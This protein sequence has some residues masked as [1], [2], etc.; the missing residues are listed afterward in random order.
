M[1]PFLLVNTNVVRPPVSPVGL[2]YVAETLR[3]AGLPV[4]V[5]D[6]A[7]EA[8]WRAALRKQLQSE[9]LGVGLSVRNTDD[10]SF[11]T[12]QSFLPW[13]RDVVAEVRRCTR[14]PVFLGGVG[15]SVMPELALGATQADGGIEGDG[16]VAVPDLVSRLIRGVDVSSV[17]GMVYRRGD[18]LVRNPRAEAD[19]GQRPL[20]RRR[21]FDNKRYE[22]QGAMVGIETKRGCAQRCI[23]CADALAKGARVR[24]R[25]P[26]IVAQE[27][28]D[29]VEQGVA[30]F[31]LGDSEFNL[32]PGHAKE[33]CRAIVNRGLG[34][35]IRWY[36]YCS[37]VPVDRELVGL[38]KS[39]G[40]AG[41]NFGVDSLSDDQLRRLG[42]SYLSAAVR[43]LAGLMRSEQMNYIVDLLVGGPGETAATVAETIEKVTQYGIR[44]AGIAAGVRVY[45]G[46]ALA[47]AVDNGVI[48]E[49]I[50]RGDSPYEPVFY[51]SPFLNDVTGLISSLVGDD[52]RFLFLSAPSG[53][54]SYNYAG[55][56]ALSRL[57][58]KGA[59]GAYWDILTRHRS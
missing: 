2:E 25:P 28:A 17:P 51:V 54:R 8:D 23:F 45:P 13:I 5:L 3:D 32:P 18:V 4:S 36:A 57:I 55:D 9:P 48:R 12:R 14:A 26:E 21:V 46:T 53:Q 16:E 35:K 58:E 40:C 34:T 38:M 11:A 59:R 37:P 47:R 24:L 56:D 50:T 1:R 6:L 43:D 7:F 10:C 15:F 29:L 41:I 20:P 39:A 19:L 27:F 44:L 30:Y 22:E 31:H 49:G 42:R 52:P 33:V